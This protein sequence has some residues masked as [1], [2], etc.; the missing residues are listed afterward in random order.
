M[1]VYIHG[2]SL[3]QVAGAELAMPLRFRHVD[4]LDRIII[5]RGIYLKVVFETF[6]DDV[7]VLTIRQ[8]GGE[9]DRD[10]HGH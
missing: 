1:S 5:F 3:G 8:M 9:M 6:N 2:I 10:R 7:S 4:K